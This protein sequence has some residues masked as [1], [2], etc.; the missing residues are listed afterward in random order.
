MIYSHWLKLTLNPVVL[1]IAT[2]RTVACLGGGALEL[3]WRLH[4]KMYILDYA[5][6]MLLYLG[7]AQY[8]VTNICQRMES[9]I[10]NVS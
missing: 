9:E 4:Q 8:F 6:Y 5:M 10:V 1:T 2:A 3:V 7:G